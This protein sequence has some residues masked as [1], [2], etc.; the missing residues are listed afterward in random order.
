MVGRCLGG[1]CHVKMG[2]YHVY[3]GHF[4]HVVFILTLRVEITA[5]TRPI[6]VSCRH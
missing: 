3:M 1:L 6:I 2:R 5:Q 4:F